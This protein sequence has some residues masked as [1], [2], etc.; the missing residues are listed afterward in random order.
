MLEIYDIIEYSYI[1]G[2]VASNRLWWG[3]PLEEQVAV[4]AD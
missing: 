4:D 3:T 1:Q 2:Y